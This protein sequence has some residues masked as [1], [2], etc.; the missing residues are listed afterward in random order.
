MMAKL[1]MFPI[2]I[3]RVYVLCYV[4]LVLEGLMNFFGQ[5][6]NSESEGSAR[7]GTKRK[8]LWWEDAGIKRRSTRVSSQ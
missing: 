1:D 8:R 7:R 3:Y 5:L 2:I 6:D 4:M